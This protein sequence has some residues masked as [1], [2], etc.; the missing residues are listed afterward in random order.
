MVRGSI[1]LVNLNPSR[2]PESGKIR[3]VLV[4][5]SNN[6][7]F[8]NHKT[9]NI[10]PLST[11]LIDDS[12]LHFRIKKRDRLKYNS[13]I[14]CD[15]IREIDVNKFTSDVLTKLTKIEMQQIEEKLEWILGF[16]DE[17]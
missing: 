2:G 9:V 7:N 4:I 11:T 3:P 16:H 1:Y 15:Y 8:S 6:L 12:T 14:V 10:L 17:P 5:Q 13:D